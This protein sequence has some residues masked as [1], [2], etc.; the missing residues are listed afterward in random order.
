MAKAPPKRLK[1]HV[2]VGEKTERLAAAA[3]KY[4]VQKDRAPKVVA[5]GK[6][7]VAQ[8]IVRIAEANNVPLYEDQALANLLVKLDLDA[9]IPPTLYPLIAEV[10]GLVF[11]LERMAKK[12]QAV[13]RRFA[14]L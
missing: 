6:G 11:Q 8:E 9:E 4:D 3:L 7:L 14:K 12:R 13:R 10:L 1:T 5:T 2:D